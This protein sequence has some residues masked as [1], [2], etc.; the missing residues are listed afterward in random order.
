AVGREPGAHR[1]EGR[2]VGR[3]QAA[4]QRVSEQLPAK[5]LHKLAPSLL[6]QVAAQAVESLA[7]SAVRE[8]GPCLYQA[9]AEVRGAAL[10]DRAVALE[11]QPQRVEALVAGR[12]RLVLAVPRQE[13]G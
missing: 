4:P 8:G 9:A 7:F 6:G 10:P 1:V 13:L 3:H 5:V 11:R 2:L 12:A